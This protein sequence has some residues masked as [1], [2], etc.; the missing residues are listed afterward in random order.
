MRGIRR[1]CAAVAFGMWVTFAGATPYG[2]NHSD[3]WWVPTESGW[4]VQFVQQGGKLIFA[5]MFVYDANRN[6]TWYVSL[7]QFTGGP[8]PATF[9]G[10]LYATTGPWFG[11]PYDPNAA[12]NDPVGTMTF[13]ANFVEH[14]T[15][16][17]TVGGV[18]VTK[19]I[20]RETLASFDYSGA[21]LGLVNRT[22]GGCPLPAPP[23]P[24]ST[25]VGLTIAQA[26]AAFT[27]TTTDDVGAVCTYTGTYGQDGHMGQ[28]NGTLSCTGGEFGNFS[29]FEMELS[30]G[31]FT[32]R[33]SASTNRCSLITGRIGGMVTTP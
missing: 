25:P 17:Y 4:G 3:L 29:M 31:G 22:N 30:S 6:P 9:S 13:V 15:L 8:P 11:G 5:T 21:Y 28:V 14:G 1:S 7:M 12:H 18:S 33:L 2:T 16:T 26:G 20:Q 24:T 10:T 32:S 27:M 23:S 19:A